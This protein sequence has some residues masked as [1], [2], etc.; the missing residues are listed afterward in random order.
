MLAYF[1]RI[2]DEVYISMPDIPKSLAL[3]YA[4]KMVYLSDDIPPKIF[5]SYF[6]LRWEGQYLRDQILNGKIKKDGKEW[7]VIYIGVFPS[8]FKIR[9]RD[10]F[11]VSFREL[12][13]TKYPGTNRYVMISKF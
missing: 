7:N 6:I 11:K 8:D 3:T 9:P 2:G 4:T 13:T 1:N 10:N 12:D 5:S